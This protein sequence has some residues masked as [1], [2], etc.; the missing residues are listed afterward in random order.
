MKC[1]SLHIMS[2]LSVA[3]GTPLACGRG[4]RSSPQALACSSDLAVQFPRLEAPSQ[5]LHAQVPLVL[6]CADSKPGLSSVRDK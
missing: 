4:G 6:V 2:L 5:N 1:L 3:K